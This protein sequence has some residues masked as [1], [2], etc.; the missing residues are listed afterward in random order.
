MRTR[1][2]HIFV[3]QVKM[4]TRR[5]CWEIFWETFDWEVFCRLEKLDCRYT[6]HADWVTKC[7]FRGGNIVFLTKPVTFLLRTLAV[8]RRFQVEPNKAFLQSSTPTNRRVSR[9]AFAIFYWIFYVTELHQKKKKKMRHNCTNVP[10]SEHKIVV[11][12]LYNTANGSSWRQLWELRSDEQLRE[13][14]M[15][16]E[17]KAVRRNVIYRWQLDNRMTYYLS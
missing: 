2:D 1:R 11:T 10:R 14:L 17:K 15:K 3:L 16:R 12:Q 6:A 13:I 4:I 9:I 8:D 7:R 5:T